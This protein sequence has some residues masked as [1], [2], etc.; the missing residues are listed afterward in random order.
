LFPRTRQR[1]DVEAFSAERT[2]SRLRKIGECEAHI[3][4]PRERHWRS[5]TGVEPT[6][7]EIIAPQT[8]LKFASLVRRLPHP[9]VA[10]RRNPCICA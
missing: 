1:I 9:S 6:Q 8:V 5:D 2:G 4:K 7:D 10:I 3:R